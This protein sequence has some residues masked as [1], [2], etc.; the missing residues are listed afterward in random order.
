MFVLMQAKK[1][2]TEATPAASHSQLMSAPRHAAYVSCRRRAEQAAD[3]HDS[4]AA[5]DGVAATA[6]T[7]RRF[8]AADCRQ[9]TD[10]ASADCH[11]ASQRDYNAENSFLI[12]DTEPATVDRLPSQPKVSRCRLTAAEDYIF[13]RHN[14][15]FERYC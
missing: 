12:E 3:S 13:E 15:F 2:A 1:A 14:S 7:L 6:S 10:A 5:A 9:P 11:A 8:S 4:E